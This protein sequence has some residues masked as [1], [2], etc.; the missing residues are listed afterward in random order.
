[1]VCRSGLG[2]INHSLLTLEALRMRDIKIKGIIINGE[3]SPHNRQALEEYIDVPIIA[4]IDFLPNITA[5]SLM[6]IQ[7]E[8]TL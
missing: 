1:M 2:T 7:P 5:Q 4:E 3:K 6:A 8:I